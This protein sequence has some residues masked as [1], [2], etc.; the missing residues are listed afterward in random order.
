MQL[1]MGAILPHNPPSWVSWT[2]TDNYLPNP[3]YNHT[4]NTSL[5]N[6]HRWAR[7]N[8]IT[9]ED[10]YLASYQQVEQV[11][12]RLSLALRGLWIS[13]FLD[14]YHK[15]PVYVLDSPYPFVEYE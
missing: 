4:S 5:S 3:F 10:N 9:M 15:V 8:P 6:L 12:L 7:T 11:A 13:Q 1:K 2:A 14:N